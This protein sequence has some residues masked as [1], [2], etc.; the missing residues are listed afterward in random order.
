MAIVILAIAT[1]LVACATLKT[2][3]C[4]IV[5]SSKSRLLSLNNSALAKTPF[6][7]WTL[8]LAKGTQC[9]IPCLSCNI[10]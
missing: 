1:I 8:Q 9:D 3:A 6:K 7:A 10:L 4:N 5:Y 2:L